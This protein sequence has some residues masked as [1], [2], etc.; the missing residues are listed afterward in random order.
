[1]STPTQE[2]YTHSLALAIIS[3]TVQGGGADANAS[4]TGFLSWVRSYELTETPV[5]GAIFLSWRHGL[6]THSGLL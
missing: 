4:R 1:M 2:E 6:E 3:A 5:Q